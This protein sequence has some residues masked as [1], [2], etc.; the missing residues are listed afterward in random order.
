MSGTMARNEATGNRGPVV[1]LIMGSESDWKT[2]HCAFER[3]D[4][5]GI[6]CDPKVVS[7]HRTP[8]D[9]FRYAEAAEENGISLIIAGAGGAAHLPGMAASKTIV[10]VIG[11]P[12]I[13]TPLRGVDAFLSIMQMPAEVGVA[14]VGVGPRGANQAALFA[15][16]ILAREDCGLRSRLHQ[17]RDDMIGSASCLSNNKIREQDYKVVI[18]AEEESEFELLENAA[19]QFRELLIAFSVR[20]VGR[21]ASVESLLKIAREEEEK[22]AVAFIVGSGQGIDLACKIA[23]TTLFPVLGVPIP[24]E[25]IESI[26]QF[27]QPFLEMPSGIATFAIGR[28]GAINAALFAATILSLPESSTRKALQTKRVEQT[29]RVRA[30][31]DNIRS[32]PSGR[33]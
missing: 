29:E 26:D 31:N 17:Q 3:L 30:M 2:M 10:P 1:G 11:V 21:S 18:L 23:R 6:R 27:L 25:P 33:I 16:T 7:A 15:A 13:A 9:L 24:S 20:T 5:L 28:P 8:D 19:T 12:V 4:A 14:T 32:L 22:G